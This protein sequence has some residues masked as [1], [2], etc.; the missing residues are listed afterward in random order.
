MPGSYHDEIVNCGFR[1]VLRP[2]AD[3]FGRSFQ[4][5]DLAGFLHVDV[6]TELFCLTDQ[7]Q[8]LVAIVFTQQN[9]REELPHVK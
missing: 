7:L 5:C 2:D 3:T 4:I 1:T 9:A 6:K 8:K